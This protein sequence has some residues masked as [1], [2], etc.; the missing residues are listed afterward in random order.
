MVLWNPRGLDLITR[1]KKDKCIVL[2]DE[3]YFIQIVEN[4]KSYWKGYGLKYEWEPKEY[5]ADNT[6]GVSTH[7]FKID[8]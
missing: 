4:V 1:E 3:H 7:F 5:N 8:S 6:P 2:N